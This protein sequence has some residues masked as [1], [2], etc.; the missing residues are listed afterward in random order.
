MPALDVRVQAYFCTDR[1]ELTP[2]SATALEEEIAAWG[3]RMAG[4]DLVVT[5]YADTRGEAVY[6][7]WLGGERAKAVVNYLSARGFKATALAVGELP[8][9]ADNQ[10]CANQRRVDVRL[11]D[12]AEEAPSRS[13]A[14]PPELAALACL[15]EQPESVSTA[16]AQ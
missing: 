1:N 7:T 4:K 5:G 10:N 14:P 16:P 9:L 3:D 2:A 15:A 6:N 12:A 8:D 13:C 11:A